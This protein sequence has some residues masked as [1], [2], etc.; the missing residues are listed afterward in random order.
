MMAKAA[1]WK[2]RPM[3]SVEVHKYQTP[4][5]DNADCQWSVGIMN[6]TQREADVIATFARGIRTVNSD[7]A[8]GMTAT[9]MR[10]PDP[11]GT[12]DV[13]E[14]NEQEMRARA[15]RDA[16]NAEL[17]MPL[18]DKKRLLTGRWDAEAETAKMEAEKKE[19]EPAQPRNRFS[20]L[21]IE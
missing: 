18:D 3:K 17:A 15:L 10:S 19:S 8:R 7:R 12:M 6:L 20:G 13:R 21:D 14:R 11:R 16:Y 9:D 4:T 1:G 2:E 5:M